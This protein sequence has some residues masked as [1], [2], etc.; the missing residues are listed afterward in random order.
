M[1]ARTAAFKSL[2]RVEKDNSY[3]NI[4][5]DSII[6]NNN[7]DKREASLASML[8][9]GVLERKITLDY[10]ISRF[11]KTPLKKLQSEVLSILRLGVYQIMYAD[12]IPNSAAVNESVNL[13]KKN[14]L[15]SASGFINGILRSIIRE[16]D[17]IVYPKKEDDIKEYLS[18]KYSCPVNIIDLWLNS[19]GEEIT[20]GILNTLF[21]RASISARV[22]NTKVSTEE[23]K[24]SLEKKNI[25][26][27]EFS[28]VE[29][30]IF[31]ENTGSVEMLEEYKKGLIHIQ[32]TASQICCNI[33]NPQSD[34]VIIDACSAPGGKS[35]TIAEIMNNKGKI[36]S[37]DLYPS[38][39]KLVNDGAKRLGLSIIETKCKDATEECID[40]PMCDKILCD[41]PCSGLGILKRK[42][43]LRYKRDLGTDTLPDIQ[44]KILFNYSKAVKKGGILVYSTCTLNPKENGDVANRFLDENRDFS[45][46]TIDLPKGIIR[47]ID[48][49]CNQ[50]TLFPHLN[51]TD[52]FFISVFVRKQ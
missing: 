44:Y 34:D 33:L 17:N 47:G 15:L 49:P 18:I 6:K 12:K 46:F 29:N 51:D 50:L 43:E 48:E 21:G 37:L 4:T 52:G 7:V 14:K 45:P 27:T 40:L 41:V 38:R 36:I 13:A 9:Y 20:E 23:I 11:S 35:F 42:P 25:K 2:V 1:N 8:F 26:V 24:K 31:L 39:L 16:K 10:I 22:N 3:S 19:Y 32:D 5:L 30:S 28:S